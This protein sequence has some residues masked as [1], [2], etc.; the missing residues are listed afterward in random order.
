Y[1][2]VE[3]V[4]CETSGLLPTEHCPTRREIFKRGTEPT[5]PDS[6]YQLFRINRET[7]LQATVYTP[8]ELVEEKVFMV[9]PPEAADWVREAGIPQPPDST[10]ASP[11]RPARA[12]WRSSSRSPSARYAARLQSGATRATPTSPAIVWTTARAST[13]PRGHRSARHA[14]HPSATG[15]LACGMHASLTGCTAC[16]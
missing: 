11:R 7:G 4:V 13:R 5:Q 14:P 16:A 2:V 1:D 3:M 6:V 15:S 8:P 9:L 10:T 12:T